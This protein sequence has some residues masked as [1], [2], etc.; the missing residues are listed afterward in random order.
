MG[1]WVS[2]AQFYCGTVFS[3]FGLKNFNEALWLIDF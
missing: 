1:N 3:A 2:K